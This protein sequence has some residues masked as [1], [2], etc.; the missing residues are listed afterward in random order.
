MPLLYYNL[1][2]ILYASGVIIVLISFSA[3]SDFELIIKV[4]ETYY[5]TYIYYLLTVDKELT[6]TYHYYFI[7]W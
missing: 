7:Y 6:R 2:S 5:Y 4:N 1:I 3:I